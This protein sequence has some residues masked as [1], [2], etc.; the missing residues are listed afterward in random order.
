MTTPRRWAVIPAQRSSAP[1]LRIKLRIVLG[2]L[3][4]A[5][6]TGP[7]AFLIS[8]SIAGSS[9]GVIAPVVNPQG[10][11]F[12]TQ[13][14]REYLS[15]TGVSLPVA[16]GLDPKLG[17]PVEP[18]ATQ[19]LSVDFVAVN[20]AVIA[21]SSVETFTYTARLVNGVTVQVAVPLSYTEQGPVLV[22]TPSLLPV[23]E[24][25]ER[26]TTVDVLD[27]SDQPKISPSIPDATRTAVREWAVAYIAGDGAALQRL[28]GDQDPAARYL[29]L[30]GVTLVDVRALRMFPIDD[31]TSVVRVEV[32][33]SLTGVDGY[34]SATE[35]D[36]LIV[37]PT[38]PNP[39]V[40]A[41]GPPG[42]GPTLKPYQNNTNNSPNTV[43]SG[44]NQS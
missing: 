38:L 3:L 43:P 16:E 13:I 31:T 1:L 6:V 12:G 22:A 36:L 40:Q 25:A 27:W 8:V 26:T 32:L 10:E 9:S 7:L 39:R 15:G 4:F 41:W 2:L 42:S 18:V 35:F 33:F 21:G 23:P 19:V 20:Q 37:D 17:R 14:V 44:G 24:F 28:T 30:V 29:G 11:A 5:A 34:R